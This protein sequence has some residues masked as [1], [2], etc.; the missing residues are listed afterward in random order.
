MIELF[1]VRFCKAYH[2]FRA[3]MEVLLPLQQGH[4]SEL[5]GERELS[6]TRKQLIAELALR[7]MIIE[8]DHLQFPVHLCNKVK[9]LYSRL[10][11][12][13]GRV[14]TAES[15]L[16]ALTDLNGD[17]QRELDKHKF[18]QVRSGCENYID[19]EH[20]FGEDVFEKFKSGRQDIKDAGNS[21]AAELFTA[22]VFHLMRVAEHGLRVIARR[23]GVQITDKNKR[24]PLQYGDWTKVIGE[25]KNKIRDARSL[26]GAKKETRLDFYSDLADKCEYLR[27]I[28]RNNISHTRKHYN[29]GGAL[30][31]MER[32]RDF[33]QSLA[34]QTPK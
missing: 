15:V 1:A 20:L 8:L 33:M 3:Q 7:Q 25:I 6:S 17:I 28:Y 34:R 13:D 26:V 24:I 9:R 14:W 16:D 27:D 2:H 11:S 10:N 4:P 31:A 22:C 21:F 29:E 19:N 5:L 30:D 32:V 12:Q 18:F 23:L